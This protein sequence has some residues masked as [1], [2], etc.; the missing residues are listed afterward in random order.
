MKRAV[1]VFLKC[2][3]KEAWHL[4]E[5]RSA[6]EAQFQ[7]MSANTLH[8]MVTIQ[9]QHLQATVGLGSDIRAALLQL[10]DAIGQ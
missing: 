2:L 4:P 10:T 9:K 7:R 5:L 6:Y 1:S 3:A 8:E